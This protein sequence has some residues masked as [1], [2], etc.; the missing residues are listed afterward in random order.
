[1]SHEHHRRTAAASIGVAIITVSDTRTQ[2]D[3]TSGRLARELFEGAGHVVRDQRIVK[4]EPDHVRE[5]VRE[6]AA[7]G[8]VRAVLLTG[9]T[10]ISRRDRT[11]EAISSLLDRRLDG[12]GEIFRSLSYAEIGSS[13]MLSRAVAGLIGDTAVFSVPGSTAAV[14][15][16][17]TRLVL[18]EVG[19]LVGEIDKDHAP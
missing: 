1:M 3:D 4:D 19:H 18:P 13:A 5:V 6:L 9:G 2:A 15:L 8:D 11:F 7:R 17:L 16:A 14:R 10:G 12:F